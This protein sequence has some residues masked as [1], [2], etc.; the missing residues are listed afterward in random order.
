M[1]MSRLLVI[2]DEAHHCYREK[3]LNEDELKKLK[4]SPEE[5]IEAKK[6]RE[7][8]RLWISG[9]ECIAR[10]IGK[11]EQKVIDLS[12]T[13]F[14]LS[15][16]GY[17]EG[18][19]FPWTVSDFSL[20][21]A[22]ES[23]IVK[24]PR[25]PVADNLSNA[26]PRFRDLWKNIKNKMPK[27]GR[28]KNLNIDPETL[29]T[30]LKTA[31]E[32]L[33]G[34]Y[35]KTFNEWLKAGI[36]VPPCFIIVCNNTATSKLIFDYISGYEIEDERGDKVP[37]K[38]ACPLFSN[39]DIYDHPIP[40][41]KTLLIDSHQL[42]SGDAL[43]P[44]FSKI[45][46]IEIEQF[47]REIIQREGIGVAEKNI[48]DSDLLREV[49]NT[50]GKKNKL[51]ADIRCVVSV[52]MLSEGWD[53]NTVTHILGV[54]AFSTQLL[55]EQVVGRALRRQSYFLNKDKTPARF[56]VEYADI[57]GIPFNFTAQAL[58]GTIKP[59]PQS[60]NVKAIT[61]ELDNLEIIFP[62]ILGY[63]L[64]LSDERVTAKF[65]EEHKL[66][67]TP[68]IIGPAITNNQAIIGESAELTLERT[69]DLRKSSII[70]HLATHLVKTKY[71]DSDGIPK[72]HLIMNM[73]NVV[74]NWLDECLICKG[75]TNHGQLLFREIADRAC[76][77]MI[78]A[79]VVSSDEEQ[80]RLGIL[81]PYNPIGS[82][83]HVN[84]NTSK[85]LRWDSS[86]GGKSHINWAICDSTWE[87]EFARVLESHSKVIKWVKNQSMGFEIPYQL[88]GIAKK[89]IPDF[90]VVLDDGMGKDNL[91][92]L[93][94]EVKGYRGEDAKEKKYYGC[95]LGTRSE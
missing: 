14:F 31:I 94:C 23:G 37:R 47:R 24:L 55:C 67:L 21:D 17:T 9:I 64:K 48:T 22:I 35:E 73:K 43:D 61:P 45:A 13:P 57:F 91:L 84:F 59:P 72:T 49:M 39:Y 5:K 19:L 58:S 79:I 93:I 74:R 90:I 28:G 30:E 1:N 29:P 52:S 32:A 4:L 25:V 76:E 2:N 86:K 34:H 56:D 88:G 77:R 75:G 69:K 81:D 62:N 92:N 11:G 3:K 89:Y 7:A 33:Y 95:I 82:T 60:I 8:A 83:I 15:S 63:R 51:G 16:S 38:G 53:T 44:N 10:K 18:T 6:N 42:E 85:K 36:D 70:L 54:R 68:E 78:A 50:V 20:M 87:Q 41:P 26:F 40:R 46:S 12:A 80:K 66:E 71:R 65:S 27:K